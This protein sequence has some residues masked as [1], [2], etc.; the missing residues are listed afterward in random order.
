MQVDDPDVEEGFPN[1]LAPLCKKVPVQ[2][3]KQ[4][5]ASCEND[6]DVLE[7]ISS[8]MLERPFEPGLEEPRH[9]LD[10]EDHRQGH[11]D[12]DEDGSK[13]LPSA[14]QGRVAVF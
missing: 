10:H 1:G 14:C 12:V 4:D 9:E 11:D 2:E 13:P 7:G 5:L 6:H 8:A 3:K